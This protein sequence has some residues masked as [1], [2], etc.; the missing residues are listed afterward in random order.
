[1]QKIKLIII[2]FLF[3]FS[4]LF[5]NEGIKYSTIINSYYLYDQYIHIIDIDPNLYEIKIVKAVDNGIGRE[6]VLSL[7]NRYGAIAAV[8]SGFFTIG[9]TYDGKACGALKIHDWYAIPLKPRGC[10]GWNL[11]NQ[12]IFDRL[13]ISIEANHESR[14]FLINGLNC[15][16]KTGEMI[17]FNPLFNK[18]TLTSPDGE[19]IIIR[20]NNIVDIKKNQGSSVIPI[21]GYV[22]SIQ[23]E[24]PLYDSFKIGNSISFKLNILS[25]TDLT[26]PKDWE[27]CDYV[28][29]GTPL[30]IVNSTKIEDFSSE[31]TIPTFITNRHSRTALGILPNGHWLFVVVDKKGLL[32]GMTMFELTE[33][34]NSFNCS[35]ALNLDGGGSSTMVYE[36]EIKNSPHGDEDEGQG[37]KI[38]RRV[39]DAIVIIPVK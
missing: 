16:R 27:Y 18:T 20:N 36:G 14:H 30:L 37:Q 8:N 6:S 12:A 10:I 23:K 31:L 2:F 7:A 13:L 34:M 21:D 24:H 22:L 26:I 15:S 11:Q 5:S 29:G 3:S 4:F 17:L 39:S 33:L 19:E 38:A 25:Q 28:V 32:D 9:T 1:M 35:Y